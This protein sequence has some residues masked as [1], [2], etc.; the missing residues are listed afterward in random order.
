M[1]SF[2]PK[3]VNYGVKRKRKKKPIWMTGKAVDK[4]KAKRKAWRT[5]LR[6]Q[7]SEDYKNYAK[8]RNQARWAT[9]KATSEFEQKVALEGQQY[10]KAF[11]NYTRN[12]IRP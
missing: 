8:L 11:W 4:V 6:T 10:P 12:K 5:F 7:S 3:T 2:I 9:R 1:E